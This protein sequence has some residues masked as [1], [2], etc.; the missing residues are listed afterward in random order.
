[1]GET[2]VVVV[3]H[4]LPEADRRRY[5]D[6]LAARLV[7]GRERR[8][9]SDAQLF[10]RAADLS[11]RYLDGAAPPSAVTWSSRQHGRWGSC[12]P[13]DRTIR[14]SDR[15]R[16]VPPWVLDAVLLHE[17]AHLHHPDHGPGFRAL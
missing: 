11:A 12:T 14:L 2:I 6:E 7:A 4:R 8:R 5:A 3:P 10:Q 9:P 13:A 17:L 15:L 1:E 16:D